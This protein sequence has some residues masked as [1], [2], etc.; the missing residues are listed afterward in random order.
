MLFSCC[1]AALRLCESPVAGSVRFLIDNL[2]PRKPY[3]HRFINAVAMK[4]PRV[5]AYFDKAQ[6]FARPLLDHLRGL[7]HQAIPEVEETI[8]WGFAAFDYQGPCCHL[9]HFK[10]HIAFGFWKAA[11][12][13]DPEGYIRERAAQGGEG[14]G[15]FGKIR[16]LEDLP[17]DEAILNLLRQAKAINDQ[18]L[19][20]PAK[21]KPPIAAPETPPDLLHALQAD[22]AALATFEGFSPSQKKEYILWITEA[23]TEKTRLQRLQTAVEW[24]REGKV[25][26]WKYIR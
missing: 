8:K 9:A 24:L 6:P 16:S 18:G 11:L 19:K 21:P 10:A 12:M 7:I 26:N 1:M 17:P 20:L 14:M 23:K 25:R 13:D 3:F 2:N 5:D 4:D 15:H 22:P